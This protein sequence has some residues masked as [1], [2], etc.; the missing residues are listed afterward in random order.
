MNNHALIHESSFDSIAVRNPFDGVEVGTVSNIPPEAAQMLIQN[1]KNG[2]RVCRNLSRYDRARVLETCALAV[3][4]DHDTF[5]NL[6]VA[7][8]GKTIRQAR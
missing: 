8:A 5:A 4:R 2:A 3:E 7:E 1:A 6:I